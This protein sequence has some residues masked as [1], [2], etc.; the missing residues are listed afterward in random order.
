MKIKIVDDAVFNGINPITTEKYLLANGWTEQ[1]R[2]NS[3]VSIWVL[4]QEN[5]LNRLWLP[6]DA[7][8]SDFGQIMGR[9]VGVLA[10]VSK[11]SELQ[12]FE[13]LNTVTIG[14]VIRREDYDSLNKESTSLPLSEAEN[15]I[16]Q[17]KDLIIF[18]AMSEKTPR[19][20]H[21]SSR[22]EDVKLFAD[23]LRLGQSENGSY[24]IKIISPITFDEITVPK[25]S[26]NQTELVAV[27]PKPFG[28]KAVEKLTTA[29]TILRDIGEEAKKKGHYSFQP[30]RDNIQ[31]GVS[32][33]ICEA[34][35][36]N[37]LGLYGKPVNLSVTWSLALPKPENMKTGFN[38][39]I[40]AT[41]LRYY[42]EAAEEFRRKA[43]EPKV[44]EGF[45]RLLKRDRGE[46]KGTVSIVTVIGNAPA[47]V[48]TEL[49]EKDYLIAVRAHEEELFVTI[50]GNVTKKGLIHWL[51]NPSNIQALESPKLPL[52]ELLD[53][54]TE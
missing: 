48:R 12:I 53:K 11:K 47:V 14:D 23:N 49:E 54:K 41:Y 20:V 30:F 3:G 36:S 19:P 40:P 51:E 16:Q 10:E 25:A 24:T 44:I 38:I 32:A 28:R 6:F 50:E 7:G 4:E 34:L 35:V 21:P 45:V 46:P 18:A 8:L 9:A 5:Q 27:P 15:L 1:H 33:N 39:E 26:Q 31:Y 43:P 17:A 37:N 22:T 52:D 42:Q 13:D 2:L 29:L